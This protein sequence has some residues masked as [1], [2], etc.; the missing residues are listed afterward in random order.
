M[1]QEKEDI[2]KAAPYIDEEKLSI[3]YT[4]LQKER[5]HSIS[6]ALI[7]A[8]MQLDATTIFAGL[9]HHTP[10]ED[11]EKID[12]KVAALVRECQKVEEITSLST[13]QE[14]VEYM[15][16]MLL[17]VCE[18][19]R[20]IFIKLAD[21]LERLKSA[22]TFSSK[23]L[24]TQALLI[25][26]P[27]A[28]R[29]GMGKMCV[30]LQDMAFATLYPE[31]YKELSEK[32]K[33]EVH[34]KKEQ[35]EKI[36]LRIKEACKDA[37]ISVRI[38]SREKSIWSVYQKMLKEEK[39]L[40]HIYD[41]FAVRVITKDIESCYLVLSIVHNLFKPLEGRLKNYIEAPKENMYQALHTTVKGEDMVFEVQIKTEWMH[42]IAE[43]GIAAH[44]RYKEGG[45]VDDEF[46]RIISALRTQIEELL[47]KKDAS[48]LNQTKE[49]ILTDYIYVFTPKGHIKRL[50]KGSTP[51]DFAYAVHTEIG[52]RCCGAKVNGKLVPLHHTLK[53]ADVVE[54]ITGA[55]NKPSRDWLRFVKTKKA[56]DSIQRH[57]ISL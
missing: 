19:I 4:L 57:Y 54:I 29:L 30:S 44:W 15:R 22:D 55:R 8:D 18:D 2:K 20:V 33:K 16:R 43:Y 14:R 27:L 40:E 5:L 6:V 12:K 49:L 37:G 28:E 34:N 11:I 31:L 50:P 39:R 35:R 17:F 53:T 26:A 45:R 42:R 9:L 1:E 21:I 23:E 10:S 51:V 52:D 32:I 38:D 13:E 56:R 24:A 25:Y 41:L 47:S 48:I 7:L 36:I 46:H 3:F